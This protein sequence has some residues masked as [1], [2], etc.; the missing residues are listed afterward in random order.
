MNE[1]EKREMEREHGCI[2]VGSWKGA[3]MYCSRDESKGVVVCEEGD[4]KGRQGACERGYV[5]VV[6]MGK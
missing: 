1:H 5:N 2:V 3:W 6:C 4:W